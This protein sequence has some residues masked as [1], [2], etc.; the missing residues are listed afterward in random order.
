MIERAP[1]EASADR[2]DLIIVGGGIYGATLALEAAL[3]GLRPLLLE[4]NDFGS[5]TSWN[6]LRFIHG[7]FRYLQSFDIG[8]LRQSALERRW[9]LR[10]FPDLVKPISVR[11]PLYD[12][13]MRRPLPLLAA[14]LVNDLLTLDR[15]VGVN[16]PERVPPVRIDSVPT[17]QLA[18][19]KLQSTSISGS[20]LWHDGVMLDSSRVLIEIIRWAVAAGARCLNYAEAQELLE[21]NGQV[22]GLRGHDRD[23]DQEFE[24]RAPV[25]VNCAGPWVGELAERWGAVDP[26][27]FLPSLALNL[28]LDVAPPAET[29]LALPSSQADGG[30]YVLREWHGGTLVGTCHFPCREEAGTP[31]REGPEVMAFLAD[32]N[33]AMPQLKVRADNVRAILWGQLPVTNP[34]QMNLRVRDVIRDHG[35]AGGPRGLYSV[36]GVKFTTARCVA[37]QTLKVICADGAAA[38]RQRS[39]VPRPARNLWPSPDAPGLT[40]RAVAALEAALHLDDVLLR[41][42]EWWVRV[43]SDPELPV[44]LSSAMGW[45]SAR[46]QVELD[47]LTRSLDRIRGLC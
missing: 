35:R 44:R 5:A 7:G 1:A 33:E 42:T 14:G 6:S 11:M 40:L 2:Y 10:N 20:V 34:G 4:R 19:P 29:A 26:A 31:L 8:R 30:V 9:Y 15:N 32:L 18:V 37:D 46:Q 21:H 38:M 23:A 41:R 12:T 22:Q 47:R 28:H 24:F 39:E 45:N 25:V 3:R 36:S 43:E 16:V 13:G 17:T 27:L